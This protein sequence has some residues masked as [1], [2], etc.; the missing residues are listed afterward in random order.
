MED[1]CRQLQEAEMASAVE[2]ISGRLSVVSA[3]E[4]GGRPQLSPTVFVEVNGVETPV[5]DHLL[6]SSL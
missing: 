5:L 3:A 2:K 6:L 4:G 1:L